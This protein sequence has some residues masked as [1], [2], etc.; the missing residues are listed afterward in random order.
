[1]NLNESIIKI[2]KKIEKEGGRLYLVG[3]AVRDEIIKRPITDEDYCVVGISQS[4]FENIFPN[5]K[6]RG[7]KFAVYE[8]NG[9]EF[10]L[11]RT[12]TKIGKGHKQ[13][14]IKTNEKITIEEDLARR[15]I[16]INSM[17]RDVITNKLIDIYGGQHDIENKIIKKTSSSF[18]EDALRV[19]RVAR[20]ASILNFS[21]DIETLKEMEKLKTELKNL[22]VERVFDEFKKALSSKR[23]S[24]FF[25]ILRK[26]NTLDVHFSEIFNLIGKTQPEKYHP[27][28]DSYNH[29]MM[30][31][32]NSALVTERLDI[33][34]SCLVHDFG[35]STTPQEILPH[36][37][38]HEERG[39]KIVDQFGKK[40][41]IPKK[42]DECG[43]FAAKEH[44]KGGIF[45]KMTLQKQV[46]FIE[47]ANKSSLGLKGMKIVVYCD[48]KREGITEKID[49]D[50]IG[51]KCIKEINGEY[52]K[53][54]YKIKEGIQL[55][56]KMHEERVKWLKKY[57]QTIDNT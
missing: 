42:W 13:F 24:I 5:A 17:A 23:P 25:E 48:K 1:M 35:K 14:E 37:Y 33:R 40:L 27:E 32:D 56:N 20:F 39:E 9:R 8:I 44:M 53:Q 10:A 19:Y 52:I 49:F 38:G 57:Y 7:K 50:I 12:E 41:K 16:T 31:L 11:A 18:S 30:V 45:H 29:T 3:G 26:S 4:R 54:R 28:G 47:K 34:Y 6:I 43:K 46:D 22:S 21:V 36:H 55:K 15:D 2:A 51:E